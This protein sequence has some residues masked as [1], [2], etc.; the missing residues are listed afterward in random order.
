MDFCWRK[1][2]RIKPAFTPQGLL[3]GT[4][5]QQV[6]LWLMKGRYRGVLGLTLRMSRT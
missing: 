2:E 6:D 4:A 1:H 3:V 5:G